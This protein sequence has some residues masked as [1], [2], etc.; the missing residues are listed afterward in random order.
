MCSINAIDTFNKNHDTSTMGYKQY[1]QRGYKLLIAGGAI[2]AAGIILI[3]MTFIIFKQQSFSI[4]SSIG[5]ISPSKSMVK[6]SEVNAGKKMAI[7][8]NYEPPEVPLNVQ[9]IQEPVPAKILDLN[10]THRLFTNFV[11]SKNGMVQVSPIRVGCFR[12]FTLSLYFYLS[13]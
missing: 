5:M 12:Y 1:M 7:A 2:L 9:V 6:T 3:V 4:N 10:F 8:I 13:F 11:P